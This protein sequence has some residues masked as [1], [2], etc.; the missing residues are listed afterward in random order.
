MIPDLDVRDEDA[1][2]AAADDA[3]DPPAEAVT[4]LNN[5]VHPPQAAGAEEPPDEPDDA[6]DDVEQEPVVD[7]VT[8]QEL[9]SQV[10]D[11]TVKLEAATRRADEIAA[12]ARRQSEMV[13]ELHRENRTLRACEIR[14]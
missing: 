2:P 14:E 7:E 13:D 5:P 3:G 9:T 11:L 6:T 12:V 4:V 1:E 8:V 10:N